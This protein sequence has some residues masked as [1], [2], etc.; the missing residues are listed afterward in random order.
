MSVAWE[1]RVN[2]TSAN[3]CKE[4]PMSKV[5]SVVYS[6]DLDRVTIFSVQA[7]GARTEVFRSYA[8]DLTA[9]Q[10]CLKLA[11]LFDVLAIMEEHKRKY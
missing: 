7:D 11:K 2:L 8:A 4:N 6:V 3:Q 1:S 9:I 10:L 5:V